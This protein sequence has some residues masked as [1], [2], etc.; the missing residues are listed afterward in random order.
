MSTHIVL[1]FATLFP[2][3]TVNWNLDAVF[4]GPG[5]ADQWRYCCRRV[6]AHIFT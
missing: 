3:A 6:V 1:H 2:R 4:S 5:Q